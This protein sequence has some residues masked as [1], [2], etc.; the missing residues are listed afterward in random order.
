[1][2]MKR[3]IWKSIGAIILLLMFHVDAMAAPIEYHKG[4]LDITINDGIAE[5]SLSASGAISDNIDWPGTLL[6]LPWAQVSTIQFKSVNSAEYNSDDWGA[7]LRIINNA[8]GMNKKPLA[9]DFSGIIM[10]LKLNRWVGLSAKRFIWSGSRGTP[11]M[12]LMP[13]PE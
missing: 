13:R 6:F 4:G 2:K 9:L 11:N 3:K 8:T 10:G 7:I 12:P 1:M 5:V